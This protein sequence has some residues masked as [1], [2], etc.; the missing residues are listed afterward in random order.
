MF[1]YCLVNFFRKVG[2]KGVIPKI[3]QK[4]ST[5]NIFR[6]RGEGGTPK[7][8]PKHFLQNGYFW[9]KNTTFSP[10]FIFLALFDLF[11]SIGA[12]LTL[13]NA[14]IPKIF[15]KRRG[16]GEGEYPSFPPKVLGNIFWA[17]N[18]TK[19]YLK[20]SLNNY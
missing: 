2:G 16:G 14:K 18:S 8:R 17:E 19:Q 3:R 5:K 11:Q 15:R 12:L 7:F 6:N 4:F 1:E 13:F 9:S 20:G 10:F